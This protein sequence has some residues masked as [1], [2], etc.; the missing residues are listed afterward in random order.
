MTDRNSKALFRCLFAYSNGRPVATLEIREG[1]ATASECALRVAIAADDS[2][3][4]D[5]LD[6][7]DWDDSE[8]RERLASAYDLFVDDPWLGEQRMRWVNPE[9]PRKSNC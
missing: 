8:W 9:I 7:P 3:T 6:D 4:F 5:D 1:Q 2:E